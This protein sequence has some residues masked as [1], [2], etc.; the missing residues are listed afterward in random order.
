[1]ILGF[2]KVEQIT[3]QRIIHECLE[4]DYKEIQK[5]YKDA[6]D[7]YKNSHNHPERYTY[8]WAYKLEDCNYETYIFTMHHINRSHALS[9]DGWA[10]LITKWVG[11]K[12]L[13]DATTTI[14][15]EGKTNK[16]SR[17]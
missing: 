6:A 4:G 9:N 13:S 16:R 11:I 17:D 8:F 2:G 10:L 14:Y 12:D 3:A 7:A 5:A 15:K 1:M